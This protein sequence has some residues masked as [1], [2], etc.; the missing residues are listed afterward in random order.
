MNLKKL[1]NPNDV[2][3]IDATSETNWVPKDPNELLLPYSRE[4]SKELDPQNEIEER[5]AWTKEIIDGYEDLSNQCLQLEAE[6]EERCKAVKV[7]L[8]PSSFEDHEVIAA[9]GRVFGIETKE[10]TFQQYKACIQ[11]LALLNDSAIP[12][13]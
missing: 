2:Q 3:A 11:Q 10:I 6:I 4:A 1:L 12:N 7:S 8:D 5:I 9:M 13:P